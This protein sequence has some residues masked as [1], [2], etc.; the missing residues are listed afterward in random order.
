M[1]AA[2]HEA[3]LTRGQK[4]KREFR[5]YIAVSIYLYLCFGAIFLYRA[6]LLS[7]HGL[8]GWHWGFAAGKALVLG[9]FVLILHELRLGE[10]TRPM[11]LVP[12][13]LVKSLL[14]LLGL[15]VLTAVEEIILGAV[16]GQTLAK[17][18]AE[19]TGDRGPEVAASCLMLWMVLLPYLAF[20]GLSE[21]IG[22]DA[23][24]KVLFGPR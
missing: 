10:R 22:D 14:F 23:L 19:F 18:L 9:K 2:G 13:I 7:E 4:L 8:T 15:L 16:H 12:Q 11:A 24:R 21:A 6:A 17:T 20:R 5:L 3:T 1:S